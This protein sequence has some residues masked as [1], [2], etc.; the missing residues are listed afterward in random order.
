MK[1]LLSWL[2]LLTVLAF[3]AVFAWCIGAQITGDGMTEWEDDVALVLA[4]TAL[5]L[6]AVSRFLEELT[7]PPKRR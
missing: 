6:Y 5:G 4:L 7:G 2:A 3:V 1:E